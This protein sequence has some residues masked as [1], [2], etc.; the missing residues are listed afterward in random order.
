MDNLDNYTIAQF[1]KMALERPKDFGYWGSDDMF[2]TWG[3]TGIDNTHQNILER[4]NFECASN[5]LLK[6]FPEDFRI[7]TYRHWAVGSVDR[8][9]CHILK[10]KGDV[11]E[12]NIT[13]AFKKAMEFFMQIRVYDIFDEAHYLDMEYDECVSILKDL[14]TYLDIMID[15]SNDNWAENLYHEITRNL[16]VEFCPDAGVYPKD[17]DILE[18]A[19]NLQIWNKEAV[20]KWNKF[21]DQN[22]LERIPLKVISP[23]Q[24]NLF[25]D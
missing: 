23:N 9:V 8:L 20:E 24:L 25:E 4:S 3:F 19:Y 11:V 6:E 17:N 2:K 16:N 12:S 15:K 5:L 1:A 7:E 22:G 21:T 13:P 10:E 14:D 18:A